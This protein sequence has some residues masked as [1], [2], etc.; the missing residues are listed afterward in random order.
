[1]YKRKYKVTVIWWK[2]HAVCLTAYSQV[3]NTLKAFL[4][5]C[6][7]RP[8]NTNS[9]LLSGLVPFEMTY[10]LLYLIQMLPEHEFTLPLSP[11]SH[12]N[13]HQSLYSSAA[14]FGQAVKVDLLGCET[15]YVSNIL[16]C[17]H[18]D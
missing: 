4:K 2:L 13:A 10:N 5:E 8:S 7:K 17:Q 9:R 3:I 16:F 12:G 1:M 11:V 14:V 18:S 15:R 6:S